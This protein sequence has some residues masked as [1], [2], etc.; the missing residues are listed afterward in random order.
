[1][2]FIAIQG[3]RFIPNLEDDQ[4]EIRRMCLSKA[5]FRKYSKGEKKAGMRFDLVWAD[6]LVEFFHVA[7]AT[8]ADLPQ[9]KILSN[10]NVFFLS[11]PA[12]STCPV[13]AICPRDYLSDKNQRTE[14]I[15]PNSKI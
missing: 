8:P 13:K 12:A 9:C 15:I 5:I 2:S 3:F 1:M 14:G 10:T 7:S 4:L 6:F 11:P